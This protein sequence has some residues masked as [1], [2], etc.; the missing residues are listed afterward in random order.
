MFPPHPQF[1][2]PTPK[3]LSF[4]G[5]SLPCSF[6]NSAIGD[7]PSKVMYS[8]QSFISCTVPL[9]TFPHIYGS[10]PTMLQKSRNSAVP[11]WLFSITPPQCVF[12]NF[13]LL[14]FGPT[15]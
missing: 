14:F 15:P 5:F 1:S 2:L 4:Q 6:L 13:F 9:P 7:C 3:Y 11:K 10:Q 12:K 8:I